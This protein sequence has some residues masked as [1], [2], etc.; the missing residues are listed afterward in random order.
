MWSQKYHL[1]LKKKKS[2]KLILR[3]YYYGTPFVQHFIKRKFQLQ[4]RP[5]FTFLLKK[6][7]VAF[8][9]VCFPS[10]IPKLITWG[11]LFLIWP[12]NWLVVLLLLS[13]MNSPQIKHLLT[14][15][16]PFNS[17]SPKNTHTSDRFVFREADA[18]YLLF[19]GFLALL[20]EFS[21]LLLF[22]SY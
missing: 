10:F 22:I 3:S 14:H 19:G 15:V 6:N 20:H 7:L 18:L 11:C 17:L 21:S 9:T 2:G 4:T 1:E 8:S 13:A 5:S 12:L 16:S